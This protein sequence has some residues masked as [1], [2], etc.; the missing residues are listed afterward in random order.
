MICSDC[1]INI[2]VG[3]WPFSCA[4][5]GHELG[6]FWSGDAS[7]HSSEKVVV[8]ENPQTGEIRIPGRA[9]RPMHPKYEAAGF[10]RKTLDTVAQI[11]EVEKKKNLIHEGLNYNQ[12]SSQAEKDTGSL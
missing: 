1:G 3:M 8:Y 2:D 11:H 7:I 4:G 9:D 6:S 10:Q 12:N 5:L